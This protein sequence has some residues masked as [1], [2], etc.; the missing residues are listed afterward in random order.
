VESL[1][2]GGGGYIYTRG[3]NGGKIPICR[4]IANVGLQYDGKCR[5][6]YRPT[7]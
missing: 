3:K 4:K 2:R 6:L 1:N 7:E 5:V